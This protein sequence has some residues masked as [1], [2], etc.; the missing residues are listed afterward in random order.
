M[1]E[2]PEVEQWRRVWARHGRRRR[3]ERVVALDPAILRNA[4]PTELDD[5]MRGHRLEE[6]G[7]I[8]KWLIAESTGPSL[9]LHF[10]MT[11]DLSW[12]ADSAGRHRHDR[13][14]VEL[15]E[16][17]LRYRNMRKFGG[18]WLARDRPEVEAVTGPLGP[19][20]LTL[21]RGPFLELLARRRGRL[22]AALMDQTWIAGVGNL[23]ADE[24]LWHA[25]LHPARPMEDL[26]PSERDV[27]TR[28]LRRVLTRWVEGYG[29]LPKG[30]L[31]HARGPGGSCP[32]CGEP[33]ERIVVGGRTTFF[34]PKCQPER[35]PPG[36]R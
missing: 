21:D 30:W 22:K 18:V 15:D 25:R 2:L 28:Q 5:A 29:S 4:S 36:A 19:D 10:G 20:A 8:G 31:I 11:G 27:L 26:R 34:C 3:V 23:V 17:E 12:N 9:L 13:V 16:G 35:S 24:V 32:R 14:V 6:P 7:R 1:P 33:L